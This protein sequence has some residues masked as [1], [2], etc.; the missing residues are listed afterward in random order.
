MALLCSVILTKEAVALS[1]LYGR[2]WKLITVVLVL[3]AVICICLKR[4]FALH[5]E[6]SASIISMFLF[7]IAI[8]LVGH[9][10]VKHSGRSVVAVVPFFVCISI[11]GQMYTYLSP[12][13]YNMVGQAKSLKDV[14]NVHDN[15]AAYI[16]AINDQLG[17]DDAYRYSSEPITV[18][19]NLIEDVS[20]TQY[21]WSNASWPWNEFRRQTWQR[22]VLLHKMFTYDERAML[23]S[24]SST[25]YFVS[26][27]NVDLYGFEQIGTEGYKIYYNR[28]QLPMAFMFDSYINRR[29]W[30]E[31]SAETRQEALLAGCVLEDETVLPVQHADMVPTSYDLTYTINGDGCIKTDEQK[32]VTEDAS[33]TVRVSFQGAQGEE[34]Y[35]VIEGLKY[36]GNETRPEITIAPLNADGYGQKK[37][38]A[39]SAPG[40]RGYSMRE[41]FMLNLGCPQKGY[42]GV[43]IVFPAYSTFSY[44]SLRV[45]SQPMTFFDERVK[46]L[47]SKEVLSFERGSDYISIQAQAQEAALVFLSVPY[48]AGWHA[49]L[50]GES[51]EIHRADLQYMAIECPGG[52]HDITLTY[53]TPWLREGA[54]LSF[55]TVMVCITYSIINFSLHRRLSG[56]E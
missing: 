36:E 45:V 41:D 35:L 38:L 48:A 2:E 46:E 22:E 25:R 56:H 53:N 9:L 55:V 44:R 42:T 17:E 28:D 18:N 6:L 26:K 33:G 12:V 37:I 3:Y 27:E 31:L 21:Y 23:L 16:R 34:T 50:D 13:H 1:E 54:W 19:A 24:L 14:K 10:P 7:M 39:Y 30:D 32:V 29:E 11:I 52:Y 40:D 15:E 43:E 47:K 8:Y 4:V 5:V 20:S 49:E 51:V